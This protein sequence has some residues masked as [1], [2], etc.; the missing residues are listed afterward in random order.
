MARPYRIMKQKKSKPTKTKRPTLKTR[1]PIDELTASDLSVFPIWEYALDEEEAEDR[2][3]TWVRPVDAQVVRKGQYSL[4]VAA[5]FRTRT[6][7]TFPGFIGVTTAEGLEIYGAVL[8]PEAKYVVVDPSN[9][10]DRRAAAKSLG[11]STKELFPLTYTL[12]VRVGRE[13]E[14]RTGLI[15]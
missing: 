14:L 4:T 13:K 12:R 11:T 3:E 5:E 15:Q 8:L 2:D 6:G 1:K 7:T 9:A 10:A